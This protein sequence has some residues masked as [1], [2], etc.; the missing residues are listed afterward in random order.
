MF[1]ILEIDETFGMGKRGGRSPWTSI[2]GIHQTHNT[3]V[4]MYRDKVLVMGSRTFMTMPMNR[5]NPARRYVVV[6]LY[7]EKFERY[8]KSMRNVE[9]VTLEQLQS[10]NTDDYVLLGGH[11][12]FRLLYDQLNEL[13]VISIYRDYGD[14]DIYASDFLDPYDWKSVEYADMKNNGY[15]ITK[16]NR[17]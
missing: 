14:S 1:G 16:L 8:T 17:I 7:P 9:F 12:M 6:T 11:T 5:W 13:C 10:T 15:T 4:D 2:P 3:L